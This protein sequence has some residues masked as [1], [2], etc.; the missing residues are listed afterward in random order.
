MDLSFCTKLTFGGLNKL[1]M[2][3]R[4]LSELRLYSC[5]QLNVE[6]GPMTDVGGRQLLQAIRQSSIAFL[7]LRRC[8]QYQSF[9]RDLQFLNAMKDLGYN[10]AMAYLFVKKSDPAVVVN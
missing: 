7:D 4:S 10:E 2:G 6:G 5:T 9:S 8:Q 1:L 3:C